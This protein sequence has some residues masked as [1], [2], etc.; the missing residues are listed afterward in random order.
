M[1]RDWHEQDQILVM[2]AV[3]DEKWLELTAA[4]LDGYRTAAFAEPDLGGQLTAV[5]AEPAARRRLSR[6]PL[7]LRG[8]EN[9]VRLP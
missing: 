5:A 7:A 8:G 3:P 6:L 1:T 9:D 4:R 2:L